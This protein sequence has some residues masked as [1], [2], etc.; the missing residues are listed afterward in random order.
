MMFDEAA[1]RVSVTPVTLRPITDENRATEF[2]MRV[3]PDQEL[4]VASVTE[5]L[6]EATTTPEARPWY[7]AIYAA[8]QPVGFLMLSW[9]VPLGLP[10]ILGPYFLWRLLIDERHQRRGFG[11]AALTNVTSWR[12]P[13]PPNY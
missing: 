7:R 11:T 8:S 6:D 4:F 10:G 3:G 5:S 2:A 1:G 9:D 13:G 12:P